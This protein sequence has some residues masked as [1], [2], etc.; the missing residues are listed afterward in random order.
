MAEGNKKKI[1]AVKHYIVYPGANQGEMVWALTCD[2]R[3]A[4]GGVG[5][6]VGLEVAR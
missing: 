2:A 5:N 4:R 3:L 1:P 6:G